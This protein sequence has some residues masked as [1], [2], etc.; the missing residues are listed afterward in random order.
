MPLEFNIILFLDSFDELLT[1]LETDREKWQW[2]IDD[3]NK[4]LEKIASNPSF[5]GVKEK[6]R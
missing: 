3:L 5:E 1:L 2:L 6:L 4:Q